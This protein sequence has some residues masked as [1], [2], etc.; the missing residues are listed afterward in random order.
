[1]IN[2]GRF[3]SMLF[4]MNHYD[5]NKENRQGTLIPAAKELGMG[6]MLMKTIR[7]KETIQ[8]LDAKEL[9]RFALSIEG[10]SGIAVGMDSKQVVDSNLDLLRNFKPMNSDEM[11]KFALILSPFFRH[12]NIEWMR[13]GYRDG[14]WG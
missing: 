13:N 6:I 8:G 7:P 3:D 9:V 5:A 12:E 11:T 1:M 4:A 2:T 14:Y 10:P